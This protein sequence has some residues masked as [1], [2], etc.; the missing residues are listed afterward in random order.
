[1]HRGGREVHSR[2]N[3]I[4][5]T[6]S[7]MFQNVALQDAQHNT[8]HYF[9]LGC[10]HRSSPAAH[11]C[12]LGKRTR[13][14]IIPPAPPDKVDCM[15]AKLRGASSKIPRRERHR[16][17]YK[18]PD[19]WSLIDTRTAARRQGDQRNARVLACAIKTV[20]QGDRHRRA[21]EAGS[22][23]EAL[24]ASDPPLIREACIRIQ[25]WYT[26]TIDRPP[27]RARVALAT[28]TAERGEIYRHLPSPGEMIPVVDP[29]F[30]F[31]VDDS[32]LEDKDIA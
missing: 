28:M 20:L 2:T 24:L 6:D 21:A 22:V 5:G 1:M 17:S 3:Y 13:F 27:P 16:Q 31:L 11:L 9:V 7:H 23:V 29:T 10:L 14:P 12:Y 4:L 15:F 18:S 26:G 32:I 30:P 19:T 8:D 25:R